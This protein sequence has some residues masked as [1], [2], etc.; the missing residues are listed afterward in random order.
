[1]QIEVNGVK[2]YYEQHG[3]SGPKVLLL[4]GWGCNTELFAPITK[5]LC[6]KMQV[7]VIDFPAHGKSQRPPQPWGVKEFAEMTRQ[8][9]VQLDLVP[10]HIIAHSFGGRIALYL[11]SH[12]PQMVRQMIITGGAGLRETPSEE[13]R[14]RSNQFKQIKKGIGLMKKI[15]L[16]GAFPEKLEEMARQKYGSADYNALDEEMRKTFVK[17]ISEDLHPLLPQIQASTLLIWGDQDTATPLWMG[18]TM[19]KEIP[20]AG[21]VIFEGATHYAYLE[22]WQRFVAIAENFLLKE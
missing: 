7:T 1:V 20:D 18:R 3:A 13:A 5:A 12:W 8:L 14:K 21:L 16:F 17:V 11:A 19:E 10:C 4:H 6:E 22:Q 15:H 2:V 9:M